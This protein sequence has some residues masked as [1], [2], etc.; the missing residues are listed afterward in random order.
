MKSML[1][2]DLG[3]RRIRDG[4]VEILLEVGDEVLIFGLE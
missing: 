2:D 1:I 3:I 4:G